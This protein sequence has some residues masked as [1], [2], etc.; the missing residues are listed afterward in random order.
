MPMNVSNDD[1]EELFL[2]PSAAWGVSQITFLDTSLRC[3]ALKRH[4]NLKQ[5][6]TCSFSIQN[7][8]LDFSVSTWEDFYDCSHV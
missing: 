7:L 3:L 1:E 4:L 8:I 6:D 5:N 2:H